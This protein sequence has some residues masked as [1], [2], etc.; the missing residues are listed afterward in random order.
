MEPSSSETHPPL[1]SLL[2]PT[3]LRADGIEI[4]TADAFGPDGALSSCQFL[5]IYFGATWCIP[6]RKFAPLF[7]GFVER[8]LDKGI[9]VV[10][11]SSDQD[12]SA[13]RT[14][15]ARVS[16]R[17]LCAPSSSSRATPYRRLSIRLFAETYAGFNLGGALGNG[18]CS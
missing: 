7:K 11:A 17:T 4:A 6:C 16:G 2:G 15:G 9:K 1:A 14:P 3:L 18:P 5:A 10:F 13:Y 12:E 8:N